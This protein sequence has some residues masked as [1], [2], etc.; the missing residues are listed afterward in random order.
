MFELYIATDNHFLMA[1]TFLYPSQLPPGAYKKIEASIP[2]SSFNVCAILLIASAEYTALSVTN[3][4]NPRIKYR[5]RELT[6]FIMAIVSIVPS[7]V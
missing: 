6:V 3:D 1:R 2:M 5:T 4:R 7:Q